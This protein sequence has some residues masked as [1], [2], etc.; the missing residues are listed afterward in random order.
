MYCALNENSVFAPR[1]YRTP[2]EI[3]KEIWD[4]KERIEEVNERLNIR[5]LMDNILSGEEVG[6]EEC[7]EV[8]ALLESALEAL[9]ELR[10]LNGMLDELKAELLEVIRQ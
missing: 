7:S 8:S 6:A 3:R 4:I 1:I 5:E 10:E 2:N 9:D